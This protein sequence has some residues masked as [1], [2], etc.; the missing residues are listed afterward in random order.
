[1][2]EINRIYN[3]NCITGMEKIADES[4]DLILS[5]LPYRNNILQMGQN[6]KFRRTMETV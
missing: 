3:E 4:I 2:L 1:M 6:D 5:D